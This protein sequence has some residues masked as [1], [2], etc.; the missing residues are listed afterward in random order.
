MKDIF[1]T[2]DQLFERDGSAVLATIIRQ[3]GPSPRGAGTKCLIMDDGS[4]IGTVGGGILEAR[5]LEKAGEI[6]DDGLP[7][8]R[9]PGGD[10]GSLSG[11]KSLEVDLGR[12]VASRDE[13]VP[14]PV[15]EPGARG[16][17]DVANLLIADAS[18]GR[19]FDRR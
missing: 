18:L 17:R 9:H 19:C 8:R 3:A 13:L 10:E 5:T 7:V 16:A 11:V 1:E 6:F 12:L 15:Q 14:E 4:F 2:I